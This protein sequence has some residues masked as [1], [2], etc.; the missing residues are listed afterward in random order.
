MAE[1]T[2]T[3]ARSVAMQEVID[4][5]NIGKTIVQLER[6]LTAAY[7]AHDGTT[8]ELATSKIEALLKV[9]SHARQT[10]DNCF[11]MAKKGFDGTAW[12]GNIHRIRKG[13]DEVTVSV[14]YSTLV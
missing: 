8:V 6:L 10:A 12:M 3:P 1:S 9:A 14:D 4:L 2:N 11:D 13:K 5:P 7:Q